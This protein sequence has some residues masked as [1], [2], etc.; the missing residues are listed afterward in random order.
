VDG[1]GGRLR[2]WLGR[3]R[4][5]GTG[6]AP[7]T[8][9]EDDQLAATA[10][11]L[12]DAF[13]AAIA[14]D[15]YGG[16][17]QPAERPILDSPPAVQVAVL[18]AA[19]ERHDRLNTRNSADWGV[20]S[21]L[22]EL[23]R[24][25]LR[26]NQPFTP[27]Q[28]ELLIGRLPRKR[29]EWSSPGQT[30]LLDA[31]ARYATRQPLPEAQ[32]AQLRKLR[33]IAAQAFGATERRRATA[34][35][36]KVL[37]AADD[38]PQPVEAI[39]VWGEAAQDGL[40]SLGA[41]DRQAWVELLLQARTASG[42]KPSARW[43]A[44]ARPLV[45][46][47]GAATC[48]ARLTQ[49]L[50]WLGDPPPA[51]QP[52]EPAGGGRRAPR[53]SPLALTDNN[54]ALL[55]GLV[56]SSM[57]LADPA[58]V[59][60]LADAAAACFKKLPGAGPRSIAVGNACIQALGAIDDRSALVRLQ[61]LRHRLV[62]IP[63]LRLVDAQLEQAAQRAGL[64]RDELEELL[65]PTFGLV[66]G[67]RRE[68]FGEYVAEL[69]LSASGGV[70]LA[71]ARDD[72]TALRTEPAGAR[73]TDPDG[74]KA[75]KATVGEIRK[76]LPAQRGRLEALLLAERSW[77]LADW[78]ERYLD[79]G[80]LAPLARR[81]IWW[82]GPPGQARAGIW[83]QDR[84][85]GLDDQP[86][87][88]LPDATPVQLWHPL[89]VTPASVLAWRRWLE[90]HQVSQPFKQAHREIYLLT[91]AELRTGSYSNRFAAHILRQHQMHALA[92]QR[93][94]RAP[95]ALVYD[96]AWD[97]ILT[98][99]LPHW[100]I[101][102]EFSVS[103]TFDDPDP[104]TGYNDNGVCLYVATDQVRFT[105]LNSAVVLPL[106]EVPA[107]VFSEVM[108]DVDLFVG[109][110]SVGNDPTWYDAGPVR[111]R[112]YWRRYA[113]GSLGES[114]QTRREV[115]ARLLPRLRIGPRCTL[116]DRFLVVRG[117]LRTY[118]IHLGSGNILM[119]PNSQYLCIVPS[120]RS[121]DRVDAGPL[122][123]PFEGDH[124]LAVI[125]SKALL[126]ADDRKIKDLTIRR[127]I[128]WE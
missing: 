22:A 54:T 66:E 33:P 120:P 56:W 5:G 43:L 59:P 91:E 110:A 65:T 57:L 61:W 27:S 114:A 107:L 103:C 72:G 111:H 19:F 47:V 88:G 18:F 60:A 29:H 23:Q 1:L 30:V 96:G 4:P 118:R 63:A 28:V 58:L 32:L 36:D 53:L 31:I 67:R 116:D 78:R 20:R 38:Q 125:L 48:S 9:P 109:V 117:D 82:F 73:R 55:K 62:Y 98:L 42:A 106:M 25:L 2:D 8:E 50:G 94:W 101:E 93:G 14:T 76:V 3:A 124:L 16:H 123:L 112:D 128:D 126:L 51:E 127:Q 6:I 102:A 115:L 89:G 75:L 97:S 45:E 68:V 49:W 121:T 52:G 64:A 108:R 79:H 10:S 83:W 46:A 77:P 39:G 12:L 71:W 105:P 13:Q 35:F 7:R 40:D 84:I 95:L 11:R 92:Q 87:D 37:G 70:E 44:R 17:Q 80:L 99:A 15:R 100:Q 74:L 34:L 113:F 81:L 26:R 86:L 85:V 119:E 24:A 122:F 21:R 90:A 41:V 69:A 104:R